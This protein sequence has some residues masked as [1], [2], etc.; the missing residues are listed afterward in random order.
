MLLGLDLGSAG[1]RAVAIDETGAV[2]ASA[3][4]GYPTH[5]PRP[6]WVEQ[7]P[8]AWWRAAAHVLAGVAAQVRGEIGGLGL[9]GQHGGVFVDTAGA[10]VRPAI[11]GSDRR[12]ASQAERISE[13]IGAR[14]LIE[15]SGGPALPGCEA[16]A[17]LWLRD[18]E[19]VQFRHTR[20]VLLPKDH[21]RLMLTGEAATDVVDAA[22]TLLLDLRRRSW[23]DEILDAL[24]IP[25]AWMPQVHESLEIAGGLRPSLAAELGLPAG[26]PVAAGAGE[27]AA[28]AV[29]TGI[30]A[31]GLIGSSIDS[32]GL[33]FAPIN[34]AVADP[35]G[36][37]RTACDP[38]PQR[39]HLTGTTPS[40]GASLRWWRDILGRRFGY[41]E[42]CAQADA[43]AV[44]ADSLFFVPHAN[45][46]GTPLHDAGARG[47][48]VGLRAHHTQADLTR[49]VME[50]VVFSLRD[51][52][53]VMR[54]LGIEPRQVR[55]TG[56]GARSRLWRQMQ[57][58]IF[59]VPV[60]AMA[61]TP[62]PAV[63]AALLAGVATGVFSDVA[64]ASA[65]VARLESVLEPDPARA[66]RYDQLYRTFSA[67][68][69]A[70]RHP[71]APR[72]T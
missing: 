25:V 13:R 1:A 53:D 31:S 44:G 16:P 61:S 51:R 57:A 8:E 58:D 27:T 29:S 37:L 11:L 40:A 48:F 12:A 15:I 67:L 32:G 50:G 64:A 33:L 43:V 62:N 56:G 47:A 5:S 35:G 38:V 66:A 9:T 18:V 52:L 72:A 71:A 28:A 65:T 42:L 41:E 26:L 69:P 49:A 6:G 59:A 55:A 7:D 24:E 20:R 14:R 23:S 19:P 39:Y 60:A 21:V 68:D 10:P 46:E 4:L 2:L 54:A 17:I 22:A 36:R 45:G 30:V 3:F 34:D 63:G 70:I